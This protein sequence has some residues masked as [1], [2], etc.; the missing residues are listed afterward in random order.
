MSSADHNVPVKKST[1]EE[2]AVPSAWRPVFAQ[3]VNSFVAQDFQLKRGINGV[4]EISEETATQI[5]DYINDYGEELIELPEE[6]WLS[7]IYIWM[8]PHWDV[9]VDLWTQGEGRSDLVL[10]VQVTEE[11]DNFRFSVYMVNVP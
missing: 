2:L 10:H 5:R 1:D 7:S 6:T 9:L 4:D 3:I 8:D 11:G